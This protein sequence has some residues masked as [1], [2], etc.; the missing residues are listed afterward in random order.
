MFRFAADVLQ[1]S[2]PAVCNQPWGAERNTGD[3]PC[4]RAGCRY[5]ARGQGGDVRIVL[6]RCV[7]RALRA[8]VSV[9]VGVINFLVFEGRRCRLEYQCKIPWFLKGFTTTTLSNRG[10]YLLFKLPLSPSWVADKLGLCVCLF[11]CLCRCLFCLFFFPSLL[12]THTHTHAHT[13]FLAISAY[14]KVWNSRAVTLM[15]WCVASMV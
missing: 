2:V 1:F 11:L 13:P 10:C 15:W 3:C 7:S 9:C 4:A 6:H 8:R 5:L 12:L 14:H